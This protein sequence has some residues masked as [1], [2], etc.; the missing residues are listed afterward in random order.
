[1]DA[2]TSDAGTLDSSGEGVAEGT[3]ETP[4]PTD[5]DDGTTP[6][7]VSLATGGVL[8]DGVTIG[9][10]LSPDGVT[11]PDG[12][13][14]ADGVIE[15]DGVI[16][17]DGVTSEGV[18][19]RVSLGIGGLMLALA[20]SDA[21]DTA[22]EGVGTTSEVLGT[23]PDGVGTTTPVEKSD[24]MLEM[25]LLAGGRGIDPVGV[26]TSESKL[27]TMLGTTDPGR[28]DAPDGRRLEMSESSEETIGGSTPDAVGSG[29]G[30]TGAVGPVV[31]EGRTPDTSETREDS[32]EGKSSGPE[33]DATSEVGIAP[34]LNGGLVGVGDGTPVPS[35]V[36]MPTT[37]PLEDDDATGRSLNSDAGPG[38]GSTTLLGTPPVE[39]ISGL[40]VGCKG[41]SNDETTL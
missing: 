24:K 19:T 7:I 30:V 3:E 40:G 1:V 32:M 14:P 23:T 41:S 36:V 6:E 10:E 26:G 22:P 2:E 31:P 35:A 34:E 17:A 20:D 16:P 18:G 12:V 28:S 13:I 37:M 39:P 33:A 5:P 21:E 38:V 8:A 29:D 9:I 27:D 4:L 11:D 15:P 25:T